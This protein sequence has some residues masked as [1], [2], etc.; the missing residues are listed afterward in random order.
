MVV[1]ATAVMT[2]WVSESLD[3]STVKSSESWIRKSSDKAERD[4]SIWG[5]IAFRTN[6]LIWSSMSETMVSGSNG[7]DGG[8]T[9]FSR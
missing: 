8:E 3:Q 2:L 5:L 9:G 6:C 7:E 4:S 1:S